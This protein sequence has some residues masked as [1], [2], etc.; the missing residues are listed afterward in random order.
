MAKANIIYINYEQ[1]RKLDTE[2]RAEFLRRMFEDTFDTALN[3]LYYVK[4]KTEAIDDEDIEALRNI[5]AEKEKREN[6][7]L[8]KTVTTT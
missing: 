4:F 5:I 7:V 8:W 2:T 1:Y 6:E 3:K